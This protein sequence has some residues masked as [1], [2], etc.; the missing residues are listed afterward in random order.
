[1]WEKD[2]S[3][4]P[5]AIRCGRLL[6][7]HSRESRLPSVLTVVCLLLCFSLHLSAS[8]DTGRV[9]GKVLD[10]HGAPVTGARVK[11]VNS[12][13]GVIREAKS[14]EQGNFIFDGVEPSE[15][16]L[17]AEEQTFVSV[18]LDVSVARGR[19]DQVTLQ[20]RQLVSVSQAITV[21]LPPRRC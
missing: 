2:I 19:Q 17:R 6:T 3:E 11:L 15:Y 16:Q 20:F 8:P 10:P 21:V 1:M 18:T 5:T 14:D 12:A 7:P 13:G 4:K 9:S